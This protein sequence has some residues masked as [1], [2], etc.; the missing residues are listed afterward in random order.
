MGVRILYFMSDNRDEISINQGREL[1]VCH[2]SANNE[3][4]TRV[5]HLSAI[6]RLCN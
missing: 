3:Y 5:M 1:L 2:G 4:L 6:E